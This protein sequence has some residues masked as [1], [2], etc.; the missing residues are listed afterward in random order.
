VTYDIE[1]WHDLF[2]AS[3]GSAAALAGLVFVAVSI[4][5]E[6]ILK[7]PGMADRGFQAVLLLVAAVV[8]SLFAL[9]PQGHASF[10]VQVLVLSV[11]LILWFV[12][13]KRREPQTEA[14]SA[15][16]AGRLVVNA[17]GTLP[18]L[19]GAILLLTHSGDGLRWIVAGIIAAI[20]GGVIN[21]WVLLVEI[22]R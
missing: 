22:L 21:A 12:H 10:S 13:S 4:N 20:I 17:A 14:S 2:V 19:I 8:V 7:L 18:Y 3:A 9:V 16:R 5:I 11:G 1:P 15:R 6:A